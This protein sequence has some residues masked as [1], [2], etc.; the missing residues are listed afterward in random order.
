[1][2]TNPTEAT[3]TLYLSIDQKK[4]KF[5]ELKGP[6]NC[7]FLNDNG[8]YTI[9]RA[10]AYDH[11]IEEGS[12][13]RKLSVEGNG[14]VVVERVSLECYHRICGAFDEGPD[15]PKTQRDV[16]IFLLGLEY[17][18]PTKVSSGK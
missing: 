7:E 16:E 15:S 10:P 3:K 2:T 13:F 8:N 14:D 17:I 5:Q 11:P 1:M 4:V 18:V 9:H 12:L 6:F